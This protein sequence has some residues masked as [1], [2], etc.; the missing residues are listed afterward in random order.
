M[1]LV[2]SVY[3]L[4]VTDLFKN[5][6]ITDK[7]SDDDDDDEWF[8]N[9]FVCRAAAASSAV[10]DCRRWRWTMRSRSWE[11][12]DGGK[13]CITRWSA[14]RL[15]FHLVFICLPSTLSVNTHAQSHI[16]LHAVLYTAS[17]LGDKVYARLTTALMWAIFYSLSSF[18]ITMRHGVT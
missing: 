4:H 17:R 14:Q 15:W 1:S 8:V 12:L 2:G 13:F 18:N 7:W 16:G 5:L 3:M 11:L 6:F 10:N 9:V